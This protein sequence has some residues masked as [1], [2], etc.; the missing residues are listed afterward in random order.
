MSKLAVI[1]EL[2]ADGIRAQMSRRKHLSAQERRSIADD[3]AAV[4]LA[5]L[6]DLTGGPDHIVQSDG[7]TF[8]LQHPLA[9]RL[10]GD[11]LDCDIHQHLANGEHLESGRYRVEITD[12]GYTY[13]PTEE[14]A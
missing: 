5:R 14:I 10:T 7:R 4:A 12:L 8:T 13:V 1:E 9:E 2:V 3:A 6:V 11:L